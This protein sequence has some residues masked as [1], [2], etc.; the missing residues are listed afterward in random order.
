MAQIEWSEEA[1]EDL[2]NILSYFS[3]SSIQYAKS[4][5]ER[6]HE[7]LEYIKKFPQIGHNVP[8]SKNPND[9]ELVIQKYRLIYRFLEKE[10]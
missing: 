6:I 10:K 7:A 2:D 4:F 9:R 5:F 1:Q 8:E 3:K